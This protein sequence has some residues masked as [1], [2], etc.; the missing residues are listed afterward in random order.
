MTCQDIYCSYYVCRDGYWDSAW[1]GAVIKMILW[2]VYVLH[3][4]QPSLHHSESSEI[5]FKFVTCYN[6][7]QTCIHHYKVAITSKYKYMWAMA[8]FSRHIIMLST[9]S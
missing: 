6:C 3:F 5:Y 2:L 1:T 4:L 7:K 9:P 8:S